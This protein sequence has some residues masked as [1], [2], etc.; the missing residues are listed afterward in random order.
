MIRTELEPLLR[1]S[2]E[3]TLEMMF[4][5]MPDA[6][7]ANAERPDGDLVVVRLAFQ[8]TPPGTLGL[9][10][11]ERLAQSLA[12][13]FTG[14]D[15]ESA[16]PSEKVMAVIGELANM[17]CGAVL[18]KIESDESFDLETP[19]PIL[20]PAGEPVPEFAG[21]DLCACRFEFAEGAMT[22][23]FLIQEQA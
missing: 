19:N 1:A 16:L 14:W 11:S 12:A 5:T 7:S 15:E 21:A 20:V 10:V 17:V 8:G 22:A 18:S 23:F 6:V 4:F 9:L 13:N 3:K 2:L